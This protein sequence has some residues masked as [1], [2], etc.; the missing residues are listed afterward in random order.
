MSPRAT[1]PRHSA[2][3]SKSHA[4]SRVIVGNLCIGLP[5]EYMTR[6]LR[7]WGHN[8]RVRQDTE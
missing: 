5:T 6:K 2:T 3:W 8:E 7:K 1:C 4:R